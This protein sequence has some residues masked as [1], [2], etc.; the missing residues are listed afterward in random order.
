MTQSTN[1][2]YTFTTT[3]DASWNKAKLNYAV[4]LIRNSDGQVLNSA[5]KEHVGIANI[6]AG[7]DAISIYPNPAK[8][9]AHIK[10]SLTAANNAAIQV[11]DATGRVVNTIASQNLTAGEHTVDFSTANL[12]S[13]LYNVVITTDNGSVTERL[14]VVK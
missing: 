3:L 13:G 11:M 5:S 7:V 10:F 4:L 9:V 8:D 6:K 1:Y 12:A 2:N 14:S